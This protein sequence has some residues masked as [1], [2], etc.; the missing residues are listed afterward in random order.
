[1][2]RRASQIAAVTKRRYMP[3]WLP[4]PG[5]GDFIEERRLMR[6]SNSSSNG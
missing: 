6:K 3:P 2:K 5:H 4:Q 1:V